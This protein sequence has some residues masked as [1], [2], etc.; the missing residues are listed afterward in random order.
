MSTQD[1]DYS[2]DD[3]AEMNSPTVQQKESTESAPQDPSTGLSSC[4]F[5]ADMMS[6]QELLEA[7]DLWDG[8]QTGPAKVQNCNR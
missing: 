1:L 3:I 4:D 8:R 6:T 7:G 2:D 5:D